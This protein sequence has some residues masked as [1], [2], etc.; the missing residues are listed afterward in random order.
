MTGLKRVKQC[1]R[2]FL[3]A[4]SCMT[5]LL[6]AVRSPF[7]SISQFPSTVCLS[8]QLITPSAVAQLPRVLTEKADGRLGSVGVE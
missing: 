5:T 8:T 1:C 4:E 6:L 2:E 3:E 7:R